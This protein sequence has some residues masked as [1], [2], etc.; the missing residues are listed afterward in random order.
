LSPEWLDEELRIEGL[1]SKHNPEFTMLEWC[2][3]LVE[4]SSRRWSSS[5]RH[6]CRGVEFADALTEVNDADDRRAAPSAPA[7]D[8]CW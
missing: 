5:S 6:T 7:G 8:E 2:E 4:G 3:A 1:P